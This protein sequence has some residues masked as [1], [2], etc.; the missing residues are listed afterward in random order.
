MLNFLVDLLPT[1]N[2]EDYKLT[3]L[4]P[5]S[6]TEK[7]IYWA[8]VL[9]PVWWL[10]GIQTL[11]FP[12]LMCGLFIVYFDLDKLLNGSI[13]ASIWAWLGM[14]LAMIL[15]ASMG[16]YSI[17]FP[18]LIA[19]AAVVTFLKSYF[20]I[21]AAM[22]LP[23]LQR[24]RLRVITR[25][26]V[27]LSI[28][29]LVT[30]VVL[31][32]LL[33]LGLNPP[34]PPLT[35]PSI[36][37]PLAKLIP[38]DKQ[39]LMITL[40]EIQPFFG[41]PM[42]RVLLYTP[43]P[44]ILGV[45]SVFCLLI[46]LGESDRRLKWWAISGCL[47]ALFLCFSRIAWIAVPFMFLVVYCFRKRWVGLSSLWTGAGVGLMGTA[48]GLTIVELIEKPMEV[49]TSARAESSRDRAL[50]V[51]KTIEAW[52]EYP[53]FGWGVIRGSVRW[54]IYDISLGSFSTYSA[55]LYLHGVFGFAIFIA[56]L[57]LTLW[58]LWKTAKLGSITAQRG[59]AAM[60]ALCL[61]CNATPLS[62]MAVY[63]WY[64]FMWIGAILYRGCPQKHSP[65]EWEQLATG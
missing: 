45:C 64:F 35:A 15:T 14:S 46:C 37:P 8:I 11:L 65:S 27:W 28:G 50:V 21:F 63:F 18:T 61:M 26:V 43:D 53:W 56:A 57:L 62:W 29:Y 4:G 58:D 34:T 10:L 19:A 3:Q 17:G 20:M 25:A 22:V 52:L 6:A 41:I 9:T 49:F 33:Y 48:L 36:I 30:T 23:F 51:G 16:L 2:S 7:I 12:I 32:A 55:I 5:L 39:A 38:G 42:P 59:F 13:P 31:L 44:P 54:Y 40:A 60:I 47:V 1:S 24:I